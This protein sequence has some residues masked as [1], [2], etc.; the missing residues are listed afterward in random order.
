M[1]QVKRFRRRPTEVEAMQFDGSRESAEAISKAFGR[2]RIEH[3]GLSEVVLWVDSRFVVI[4]DFVL[5]A[6]LRTSLSPH[7]FSEFYEPIEATSVE[8]RECYSDEN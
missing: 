4:G 2:C 3:G 7:E 1:S 8:L 6:P 5:G